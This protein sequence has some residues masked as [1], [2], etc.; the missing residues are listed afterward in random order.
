MA[1]SPTPGAPT[2]SLGPPCKATRPPVPR[3]LERF[4]T[5]SGS[6]PTANGKS[7]ITCGTTR[8]H[9]PSPP[10]FLHA[11]APLSIVVAQHAG[12][13]SLGPPRFARV[14]RA[15]HPDRSGPVFS[16]ARFLCAGPRSG[17]IVARLLRHLGRW[18]TTDLLTPRLL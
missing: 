6:S 13:A 17:G 5:S 3:T 9:N 2:K 1:S 10:H 14:A 8:L 12:P 7:P 16:C 4:C 18:D 15:C 11:Q